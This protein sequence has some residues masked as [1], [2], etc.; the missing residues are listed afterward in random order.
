VRHYGGAED[1]RALRRDYDA[2]RERV[3]AL[4]AALVDV[5][6]RLASPPPEAV[7]YSA[8]FP[9]GLPEETVADALRRAKKDDQR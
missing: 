8:S 1:T 6:R 3:D 9:S 5:T 7:T 2:E 4:T